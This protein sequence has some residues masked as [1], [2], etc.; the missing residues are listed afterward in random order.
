MQMHATAHLQKKAVTAL[1]AQPGCEP[2]TP[3]R[4]A[5][6]RLRV[7]LCI[8]GRTVKARHSGA[9]LCHHQTG[10]GALACRFCVGVGDAGH[11]LD[12]VGQR[13]GMVGPGL[14]RRF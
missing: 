5:G 11:T 13:Q 3:P 9:C 14:K 8:K 7:T 6:E 1:T 2:P 4:Q 10:Q 12:D